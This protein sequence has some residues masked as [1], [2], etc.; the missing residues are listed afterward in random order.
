MPE[1]MDEI[2]ERISQLRGRIR[3]ALAAGEGAVVPSLRAELRAAELSWDSALS[4]SDESGP[5]PLLETLPAGMS[6]FPVREQVHQV[7]T[8]LGV[9]A[10]PR[11]IVATHEALFAGGLVATKLASLRRD[12]ER[13]FRAAPYS[14]PYYVCAALTA[15]QLV[16]VRGLL[17]ISTWPL[18][19][20][21]MGPLS[22]RVDFL[23]AAMRLVRHLQSTGELGPQ[24]IR[25]LWPFTN[26]IPGASSPTGEFEPSRLIA[27]A[28]AELELHEESDRQQREAAAERARRLSDAEQLFG[29][30]QLKAV[31]SVTKR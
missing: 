11:L 6:L 30:E 1:T 17:A 26:N 9:A 4:E 27:A 19:R 3:Q 14:R 29:G 5:A 21:I 15:D 24:S 7:L 18:D 10:A 23:T 16:A 22:P 12:E 13:S 31:R 2:E 20:R 25:L 28:Q 8:V